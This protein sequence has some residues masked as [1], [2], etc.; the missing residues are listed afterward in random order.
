[1]STLRSPTRSVAFAGLTELLVLLQVL[2]R[3]SALHQASAGLRNLE[4][5][6]QHSKPPAAQVIELQV[7]IP[8]FVIPNLASHQFL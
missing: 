7:R 4:G 3:I 6:V 8:F 1:M 2:S 5:F